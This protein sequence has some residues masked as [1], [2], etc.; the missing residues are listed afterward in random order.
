VVVTVLLTSSDIFPELSFTYTF[1]VC[2]EPAANPVN[3]WVPVDGV[4]F[5]YSLLSI[6]Y[7]YSVTSLLSL[8]VTL[9][10]ISVFVTL[11][12]TLFITGFSLSK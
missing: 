5:I 6:L 7:Q 3:L 12:V 9:T 11:V 1:I 2:V 4:S 8:A 10:V